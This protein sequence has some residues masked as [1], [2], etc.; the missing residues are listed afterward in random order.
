MTRL[1]R[2]IAILA[3]AGLATPLLA[4]DKPDPRGE[5]DLAKRLQNRVAGKP[6]SCLNQRD[7]GSSQ[8][9]SGTAIVYQ[10]G[11]TLYVNRPSGASSLDD[12]DI[13]VTRTTDTQ[14]CRMDSVRLL[15][16]SAGFEHG[17]VILG[18]FVPYKKDKS[19]S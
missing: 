3:L 11:N 15:D 17:F 13:L 1:S 2:M 8:I 14:L 18:D 5:A 4:A 10:I 6:V 7:L 16:R 19:K 12:D 9:I